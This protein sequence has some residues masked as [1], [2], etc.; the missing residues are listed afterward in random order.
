MIADAALIGLVA[1]VYTDVYIESAL[2]LPCLGAIR[3]FVY[4]H[5]GALPVHALHVL[6]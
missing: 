6:L 3:A 4:L 5:N 1:R 2:G